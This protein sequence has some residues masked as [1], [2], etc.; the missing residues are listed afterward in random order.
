MPNYSFS[1]TTYIMEKENTLTVAPKA[2]IY[3]EQLLAHKCPPVKTGLLE[4]R[5]RL[6]FPFQNQQM[7][8]DL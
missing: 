7:W 8:S 3:T 2:L 5:Y 1:V 4:E 6:H